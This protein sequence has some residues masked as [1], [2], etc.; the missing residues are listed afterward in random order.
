MARFAGSSSSI[1]LSAASAT[2]LVATTLYNTTRCQKAEDDSFQVEVH[3]MDKIQQKTYLQSAKDGIPSTLRILAIDLP[4]MRKGAFSGDCHLS[5]DKVFV[6]EI[7]PPKII[8][9]GEKEAG[10]K[11]KQPKLLIAQKALVKVSCQ[12][13]FYLQLTKRDRSHAFFRFSKVFGSLPKPSISTAG[14]S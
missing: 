8:Q 2:A 13:F 14:W 5:H 4:E 9:V 12:V 6:D 3:L 1:A 11:E 7:A 10:K